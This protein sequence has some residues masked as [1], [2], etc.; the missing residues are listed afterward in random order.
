[1]LDV[2]VAYNRYKF[3]G[4]EFLTW[5]WYCME[6][7]PD[8][9]TQIHPGTTSLTIG[10]RIVLENRTSQCLETITIRGDDA[11]L[12]EGILAL[13]KGAM[14]TE[15]HLCYKSKN[16]E[17]QFSIKGESLGLSNLKLP[18]TGPIE[19]PADIE[20][21]V[22][23]KAYLLDQAVK[24]M[25]SLYDRFIRLRVSTDW[26]ETVLPLIKGWIRARRN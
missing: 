19:N 21:V 20:G 24:L 22:L 4:H 18:Q 6:T 12:E 3:I 11:G 23:E 5:L 1:M 15:L 25:E 13:A 16:Q 14:V 10:N 8:H 26:P 17:W 2:A 9:L 7:H